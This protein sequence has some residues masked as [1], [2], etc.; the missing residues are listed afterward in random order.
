MQTHALGGFDQQSHA[1]LAT[2]AGKRRRRGPEQ[3][4]A[5][6]VQ[7]RGCPPQCT[8]DFPDLGVINARDD[9]TGE[10]S[11][12]GHACLVAH[13]GLFAPEC[14]SLAREDRAQHGVIG[15]GRLNHCPSLAVRPPCPARDL[16]QDLKR[17]LRA[18]QIAPLQSH[19]RIDH[20]HQCQLGKIVALGD[21]LRADDDISLT[22]RDGV[23]A[24]F[25]MPGPRHEVR[26]QHLNPSIRE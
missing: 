19:I 2:Q 8:R 9:H 17:L 4:D 20:P 14:L 18:A 6:A 24:F 15:I 21:H 10:T 7:D 13:L 23:E 26:G 3:F 22:A 11:K 25:H 1:G 16:V 12:G 5:C